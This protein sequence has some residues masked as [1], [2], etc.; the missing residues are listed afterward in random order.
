MKRIS[1]VFV[2]IIALFAAFHF[3]FFAY[4]EEGAAV[5][6]DY[7][8]VEKA[9]AAVKNPIRE[10]DYEE[11]VSLG[12]AQCDEWSEEEVASLTAEQKNVFQTVI[13]EYKD[14]VLKKIDLLAEE[15]ANKF[16]ATSGGR[17]AF[18]KDVKA[19]KT[20]IDKF[21]LKSETDKCYSELKNKVDGEEYSVATDN[22]VSSD[23]I[24]VSL[25]TES[26]EKDFAEDDGVKVIRYLNSA[27][28]R[29]AGLALSKSKD[30][31]VENG[32][33]AYFFTIKYMRN[34]VYAESFNS[35]VEVKI[36]LSDLNLAGI[37]DGSSVQAGAYAGKGKVVLC[38]AAIKDGFFSF[39][40]SKPGDYFIVAGGYAYKDDGFFK[41]YGAYLLVGLAAIAVAAIIVNFFIR[42]KKKAEKKLMKE[43]K[44]YKK[45]K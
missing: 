3:Q 21:N 28:I 44:E 36:K 30:M 43:F 26:G 13:D 5:T 34:G 10:P 18:E 32:G 2:S 41:N 24:T 31:T 11:T 39:T 37:K 40:A 4:A 38:D 29:N 16:S 12:A 1:V 20:K 6:K 27:V 35:P 45:H 19:A 9:Y 7:S 23:G 17:V 22:I 25:K 33:A 14:I 42:K 15:N 8:A